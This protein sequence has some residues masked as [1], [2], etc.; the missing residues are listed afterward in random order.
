[1]TSREELTR[2][3]AV[4]EAHES[5]AA[6]RATWRSEPTTAWNIARSKT[7]VKDGPLSR[8]ITRGR[9]ERDRPLRPG[10]RK[11]SLLHMAQELQTI[12]K[13]CRM[14]GY[15]CD[16]VYDGGQAFEGSCVQCPGPR[17]AFRGQWRLG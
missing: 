14:M 11:L 7:W 1:M 10:A 12:S 17:P 6:K 3:N 5:M 2:A 15:E 8:P 13:A 9:E 4:G 16:S